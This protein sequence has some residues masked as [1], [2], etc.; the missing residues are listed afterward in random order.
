MIPSTQS[1]RQR[2]VET[3]DQLFYEHGFDHTSFADIAEA[4]ALSRGNFY[5]HFRTKDEILEAVIALRT[6]KTQAMLDGWAKQAPTALGRIDRF[7]DMMVMNSPSIRR[8]GCPVGTL[9]TE[10]AKLEH[11]AL[12]QASALFLL[13][14]HWLA[15]QFQ[16][17]G[18]VSDADSL[19]MHLLARSQGIATLANAFD[20]EAFIQQETRQLHDWLRRLQRPAARTL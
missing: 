8:H 9:C 7:I 13:F 15:A 10:L 11:P 16:Q 20:D 18:C 2:I 3:A 5:Y 17:L 6:E 12:P 1:T 14:R 19:A 4:V